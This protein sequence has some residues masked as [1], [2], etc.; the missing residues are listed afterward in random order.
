[1]EDK[2]TTTNKPKKE[3][4]PKKPKKKKSN[5]KIDTSSMIFY[6]ILLIGILV[7]V[8]IMIINSSKQHY[9]AYFGEDIRVT[10][11]IKSQDIKLS[12][13]AD[14]DEPVTQTGKLDKVDTLESP[15]DVATYTDA[16]CSNYKVTFDDGSTA[17]CVIDKNQENLLF[18]TSSYSL[19][20]KKGV[21][22]GKTNK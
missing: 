20:F 6:T 1:M 22:D 2:N 3:D 21:K 15:I 14:S 17:E 9:E 10:I 8:V 12:I 13:Y 11:D 16:E 7:F 19:E 18:I 5:S 4:K